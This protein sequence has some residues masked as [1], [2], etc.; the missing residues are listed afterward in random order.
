MPGD[1]EPRNDIKV[2][3]HMD[4]PADNE[5]V[6]AVSH[7]DGVAAEVNAERI[8]DLLQ[9]QMP[10]PVPD[11]NNPLRDHGPKKSPDEI[12]HP[13]PR[14]IE[15]GKAGDHSN[16]NGRLEAEPLKDLQQMVELL[17]ILMDTDPE[18]R[19]S[20]VD[21]RLQTRLELKGLNGE[22]ANWLSGTITVL[23]TRY[24]DPQVDGEVGM[25]EHEP[26]QTRGLAG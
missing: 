1:D 23:T 8:V 2:R 14:Q 6:E 7:Q 4:H 10:L 18:H 20:S 16:M 19:P 9:W 5:D 22:I 24:R 11:R 26:D 21:D 13:M 12:G 3:H 25:P 15:A 17:Q